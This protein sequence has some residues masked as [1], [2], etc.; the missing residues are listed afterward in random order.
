MAERITFLPP[1]EAT[2][3][4]PLP[5]RNSVSVDDS[6]LRIIGAEGPNGR[7]DARACDSVGITQL[8]DLGIRAAER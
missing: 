3:A 5:V 6:K 7:T 1:R 2:P 8:S 4:V